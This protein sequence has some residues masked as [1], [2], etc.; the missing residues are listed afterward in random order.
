MRGG[1]A[2]CIVI[3]SDDEIGSPVVRTPRAAVVMN[4]PSLDKYETLVRPGG[5]LVINESLVD[6]AS[7]RKDLQL[8]PIRANEVAE[9]LGDKRLANVVL[10]GALLQRLPV[11]SL[12]RS[13]NRSTGTSR[14]TV[15][16]CFRPT[17]RR[18]S[19]GRSLRQRSPPEGRKPSVRTQATR[20]GRLSV[21]RR[22]DDQRA[23]PQLGQVVEPAGGMNPQARQAWG[24][25]GPRGA[26]QAMH[27]DSPT[28]LAVTVGAGDASQAF[29][30]L[31]RSAERRR[32]LVDRL[33]DAF[34]QLQRAQVF[35]QIIDAVEQRKR[36]V[37][38][39]ECGQAKARRHTDPVLLAELDQHPV[40]D[41]RQLHHQRRLAARRGETGRG[42]LHVCL[43]L[44]AE[45]LGA[46]VPAVEPGHQRF[47]QVQ[48]GDRSVKGARLHRVTSTPSG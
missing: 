15:G 44:I 39:H 8:I 29:R 33:P 36:P 45:G 10:L 20:K 12:Q 42:D 47:G 41:R 26:P 27:A 14:R 16:T 35:G 7:T 4:L 34:G 30:D 3:I 19:V 37:Q 25:D 23:L 48:R 9:E 18:C 43:L 38:R 28:G 13:A 6:R 11:L 32:R 17:S 2:H 40:F 21:P 31:K 22:G 24:C 1:T 46:Q 5:V